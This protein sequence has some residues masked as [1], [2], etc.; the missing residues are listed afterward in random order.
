MADARRSRPAA[1]RRCHVSLDRRRRLEEHEAER[2]AREATLSFWSEY[3]FCS[4]GYIILDLDSSV[5]FRVSV[6]P[7]ENDE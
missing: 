3:R 6:K 5:S 2:K 7:R 1:R 4:S